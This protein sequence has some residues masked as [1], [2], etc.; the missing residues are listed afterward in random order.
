[1]S[2]KPE[3]ADITLDAAMATFEVVKTPV[4]AK[5]LLLTGYI[6]WNDD[7]IGDETFGEEVVKP[8]IDF[9]AWYDG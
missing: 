9:L 8:V 5:N 4:T 3:R 6:Y 1:M 7:L 2:E